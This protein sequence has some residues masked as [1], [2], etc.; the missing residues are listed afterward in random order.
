VN[1]EI[2]DT[3][4]IKKDELS[5]FNS[6]EWHRG[7]PNIYKIVFND[8]RIINAPWQILESVYKIPKSMILYSAAQKVNGWSRKYEYSSLKKI[9]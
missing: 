2:T 9:F 7:E 3:K 4:I 5:N 8:G 1:G 6:N